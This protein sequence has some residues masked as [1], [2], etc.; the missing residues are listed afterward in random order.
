[1]Q[2]SSSN[3]TMTQANTSSPVYVFGASSFSNQFDGGILYPLFGETPGPGL[4][5][6]DFTTD[7]DGRDIANGETVSL[8]RVVFNVS[9]GPATHTVAFT[10]IGAGTSLA[11]ES[12]VNIDLSGAT[13]EDATIIVAAIPEPSSLTLAATMAVIAALG[14]LRKRR[15]GPAAT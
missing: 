8:G 14:C 4:I 15:A 6:T 1:L 10:N 2:A 11:D 13:F 5:A 7:L 12:N 9:G 3:I